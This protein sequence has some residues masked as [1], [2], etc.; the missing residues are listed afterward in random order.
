MYTLYFSISRLKKLLRIINISN[1]IYI[2]IYENILKEIERNSVIKIVHIYNSW[3]DVVSDQIIKSF[4]RKFY[5]FEVVPVITLLVFS[6]KNFQDALIKE[7]KRNRISLGI[8]IFFHL[9][10]RFLILKFQHDN[11]FSLIRL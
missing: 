6:F 1:N 11:I 5:V 10:T 9:I 2:N 8:F 4:E 7:I 3:N